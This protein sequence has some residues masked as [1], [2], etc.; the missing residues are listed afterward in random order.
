MAG[1]RAGWSLVVC[2]AVSI[3]PTS[4]RLMTWELDPLR[5]YAAR[6]EAAQLTVV[7][8]VFVGVAQQTFESSQQALQ[9]THDAVEARRRSRS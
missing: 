4:S 3:V 1:S 7:D 8:C 2:G 5:T 9:A 6:G